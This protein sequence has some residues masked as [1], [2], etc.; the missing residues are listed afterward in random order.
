MLSLKKSAHLYELVAAFAIVALAFLGTALFVQRSAARIDREVADLQTNSLPSVEHLANAHNDLRA[1][2]ETIDELMWSAPSDKTREARERIA[3]V[4]AALDSELTSYGGTRW[5]P[6]EREVFETELLPD[7][8]RL[9]GGLASLSDS[10]SERTADAAAHRLDADVS[11]LSE[12]NHRESYAAAARILGMRQRWVRM[13]IVLDVACAIV[14]LVASWLAVRANRRFAS[15]SAHNTELLSARAQEL[16]HF[17]QRVAHDLL[18]PMAVVAFGLG[19][20]AHRHPDAETK[21]IVD[22]SSRALDRSRQMVHGI[23]NFSRSGARPKPDARTPLAAGIRGAVE[24]L[25]ASEP[26]LPPRVDVEPFRDC[27]VACDAAV[28][29]VILGNLLNNAAKYTKGSA[30]RRI[31][32]RASVMPEWV[33]VEIEDAGPGIPQ[34]LEQRIFEPYVRGPDVTQPGL[35]LGLATVK[36]LVESHDGNVGVRRLDPG[37][38]FWFEL[39]RAKDRTAGEARDQSDGSEDTRAPGAA[40]AFEARPQPQR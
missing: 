14:A 12:L 11:R 24:E 29:G 13:S 31:A 18:S 23:L 9:N 2:R 27:D 32:L 10:E 25:V 36:R 39:R 38:I 30:I 19:N 6:G 5:Y 20:L 26:E 1:L 7:L 37:T 22:R 40:E 34:G 21:A 35:G 33:R 16:E 4:R 28:L 8:Q 3:R 15:I 17:A